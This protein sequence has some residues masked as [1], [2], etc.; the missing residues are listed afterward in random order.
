MLNWYRWAP[1]SQI[2]FLAPTKPLVHQQ[3][4]ACREIVGIPESDTAVMTGNNKTTQRAEYWE[5]KR[6]LYLTPQTME[7]DIKKGI[8]DPKKIVLIV[9]DEAHRATGNYAYC[10]VIRQLRR[11]NKSFRV[12]ALTATPGSTLEAIQ[13]ITD[14]L[15]IATVE[16]R[17]EDS[18]DIRQYV[19]K[20]D[21][22]TKVIELSPEIK[23]LKD[24][25]CKC[26]QPLVDDLYKA[27]A[28]Y[29]ND[30]E[31]ITA[32]GVS[33]AVRKWMNSPAIVNSSWA[34]KGPMMAKA[35]FLAALAHPLTMLNYHGIR[36][37]HKTLT[38]VRDGVGNDGK[39]TKL[40]T[41][42][43][44]NRDCL[45]LMRLMKEFVDDKNMWSHPKMQF[46]VECILDHLEAAE[47][48]KEETRVMIFTSFRD[49]AEDIIRTL[50]NFPMVK[51]HIFV[52]QAD[53]KGG[54]SGMSQSVQVQ[55]LADYKSG[56]FNT[57]VATSIG[58]EGLDIGE[59]DLI[60]CYDSSASPIRLV[61]PTRNSIL[62]TI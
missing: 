44:E 29:I 10:Q 30:A 56:K 41:R 12:L 28:Y 37:F 43:F 11:T 4:K 17:S 31:K 48:K 1:K 50:K 32:F 53:S 26:L 57:L 27:K 5:D 45:Q 59:V 23:E 13:N 35:G 40:R 3:I 36:V 38:A 55:T 15:G 22:D 14:E 2:V 54:T 61:S 39:Q 16:I 20:K 49:S 9:I 21:I 25:Y 42:F 52:G 51:P 62:V 18:I 58:E 60:I 46:L 24:L 7:N 33:D 47:R 8:C 6:I 34:V 19:N